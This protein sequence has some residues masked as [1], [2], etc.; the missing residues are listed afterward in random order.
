M[1]GEK[2]KKESISALWYTQLRS[3]TVDGQI[4][5]LVKRNKKLK[6]LFYFSEFVFLRVSLLALKSAYA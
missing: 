4:T 3:D 2:I 6:G 1:A 5:S